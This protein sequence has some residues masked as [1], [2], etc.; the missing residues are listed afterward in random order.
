[1]VEHQAATTTH[2]TR[3]QEACC[4]VSVPADIDQ[5]RQT[6]RTNEH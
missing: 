6:T 5:Q 2:T 4:S 1:M 3:R